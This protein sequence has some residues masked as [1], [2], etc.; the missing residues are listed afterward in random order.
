MERP[1]EQRLIDLCFQLA[2][3]VHQYHR[4]FETAE[5]V[6]V[7]AADQLKQCGFPTYQCGGSWGVLDDGRKREIPKGLKISI[8]SAD[9]PDGT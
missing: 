8:V 7:W 1:V 4:E 3:S 6:A 9:R 5:H 2:I